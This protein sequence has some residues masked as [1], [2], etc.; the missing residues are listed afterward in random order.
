M[1]LPMS[2]ALK[3]IFD[4]LV[5]RVEFRLGKTVRNLSLDQ[6]L[7]KLAP[8]SFALKWHW[9]QITRSQSSSLVSFVLII[10]SAQDVTEL[11]H[12]NL[13]T[14]PLVCS[15]PVKRRTIDCTVN[16]GEMGCPTGDASVCLAE[17][18]K[19][20]SGIIPS[21]VGTGDI[22]SP[23]IRKFNALQVSG[24]GRERGTFPWYLDANQYDF[25]CGVGLS[26]RAT[27]GKQ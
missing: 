16:D 17:S 15:R 11:V 8:L 5:S 12:Q 6:K 3:L 21:T 26:Y 23:A 1:W 10:A 19:S 9:R 20:P 7:C 14:S 27:H 4:F 13:F 24:E 25:D 22:D 18:I 2:S